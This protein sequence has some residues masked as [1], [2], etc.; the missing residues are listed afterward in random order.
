MKLSKLIPA[1]GLACAGL[2]TGQGLYNIMPY[3]DEPQEALPL[4]WT[5]GASIGYDDNP[6]PM[7]SDCSGFD[8]DGVAY[9]SGFVQA[10]FVSKTPQTVWDLWARVGIIYYFDDIEQSEPTGGKAG[11]SDDTFYTARAGLNMVHHINERLRFRSRSNISYEMEPDY[12]SGIATDRRQG[13]YLRYSSDNSLGYRWTERFATVTGYRVSGTS[14]DDSSD[15]N[16]IRHL[17]Y[18][19][20]RYRTS[21]ITV[22]TSSIRYGM[23]DNN[24]GPDSDSWYIMVGAEHE[25]SATTVGVVRVGAQHYSPDNGDDQWS[26][27]FEGTIKTQIN[28]KFSVRAF[29]YFGIEDRNR[30]IWV[31]D[32]SDIGTPGVARVLFEERQILRIGSQA[33]YVVSHKLTFFGGVNLIFD[34]YSDGKY[35]TA[36]FSGGKAWTVGDSASDFDET[37][38]NVNVGASF[39]LTDNLYLTSSYNYTNS[40]SDAST[41]EYDRNRVQLGLQASF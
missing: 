8:D 4:H 22:L 32:C 12:D 7:L 25:F 21:P 39:Q 2:A 29:A 26:P 33:S 1:C 18:N 3:D 23:T 27:Y 19:Q 20:F 35:T 5:V 28:E 15:Q 6:S 9:A 16:Y 24:K 31:H 37:V 17:F 41:R 34:D 11:G 38:F 30:N 10:N 14:W 13:E 40:N 36:G